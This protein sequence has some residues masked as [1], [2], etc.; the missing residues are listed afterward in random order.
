VRQGRDGDCY[1]MAALCGLGNM[2]GLID[3]VCVARD[4]VVGV[5]GF[6]FHRGEAISDYLT[7][8]VE[9]GS[10]ARSGPGDPNPVRAFANSTARFHLD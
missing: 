10:P 5:Y 3:K 7:A 8:L 2:E 9:L 6:V 1:L 4:E